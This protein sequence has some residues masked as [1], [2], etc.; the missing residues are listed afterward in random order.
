MNK[1]VMND[2]LFIK[3]DKPM[4]PA[5]A[6]IFAIKDD[7]G[8]ILIDVGC[9]LKKF[10]KKL[11]QNLEIYGINIKKIHTILITHAHPD[12]MG[13]MS[14][15]LEKINPKILINTTEKNSALN[16]NLLNKS[17]D[18][19]L[20]N[21]YFKS[22][23]AAWDN[24]LNIN[25]HFKFLCSMSELSSDCHIS[26]IKD[27]DII[28]LGNYK[29]QILICPGHAPGHTCLY[30]VNHKY[31]LSG[32]IIGEKGVTWYSPSSG[33]VTKMLQSLELIEKMP[34]NFIL[35]SHGCKILNVQ[36]RIDEIRSKI[37]Q[38]EMIILNELRNKSMRIDEIVN[39]FF[40][41]NLMKVIGLIIVESHLQ[42][43]EKENK[44]KRSNNIVKII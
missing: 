41:N 6:N 4:W 28:K 1:F 5:S 42:K 3:A 35:P 37:I 26:T 12:H 32:D 9:G 24:K 17:F 22:T 14:T 36:Q 11:F 30:E 34:I 15:I 13:A 23:N 16:I 10:T 39:L 20:V 43:L 44:I 7:N 2:F 31:L 19:D 27:K 25:E 40:P 8:V 18:M 33:G 21:K 38:R 29:F